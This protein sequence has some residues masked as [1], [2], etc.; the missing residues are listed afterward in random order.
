M[1]GTDERGVHS[2]LSPFSIQHSTFNIQHSRLPI[3]VVIAIVSLLAF[4]RPLLRNEVPPF[5]DHSDYFQPLRW[6]TAQELRQGRLPLWNVYNASGERWLANPQTGIF[7]PPAWLFLALP[8]ATA[9]TL[10]LALH[11]MLAGCGAFLFFIRF[12]S[13]GA[14]L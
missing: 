14:A 8:F 11:V 6:F 13:N 3:F 10:F 7:Y 12:A 2:A 1:R 9:Y 4:A 5:R